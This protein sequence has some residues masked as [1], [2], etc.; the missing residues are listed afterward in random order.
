M[1][2]HRGRSH[3][4]H[5]ERYGGTCHVTWRLHRDQPPLIA[6]E[7][8][9]LISVLRCDAGRLADI[10]AGVVMDDHVHILMRPLRGRTSATLIQKWKSISAHAITKSSPRTA[11]IWQAEYHLRWLNGAAAID[12]CATYIRANPSRRWPGIER[13]PWIL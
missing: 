10:S 13:Y 12:R 4:S 5:F 8:E 7:R 1:L 6:S 3:I 11:P 2:V 9:G